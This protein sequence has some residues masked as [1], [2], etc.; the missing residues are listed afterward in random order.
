MTDDRAPTIA[1]RADAATGTLDGHAP[2]RL[3]QRMREWEIRATIATWPT[4][5]RSAERHDVLVRAVRWLE[6]P[7]SR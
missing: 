7:E 1:T 6:A 4:I 2:A 5:S 3:F